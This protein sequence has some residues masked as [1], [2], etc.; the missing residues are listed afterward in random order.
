MNSDT[1]N[2][3]LLQSHIGIIFYSYLIELFFNVN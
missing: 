3:E 1:S 2:E